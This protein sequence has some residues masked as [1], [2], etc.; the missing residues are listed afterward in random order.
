MKVSTKMNYINIIV[1]YGNYLKGNKASHV[2]VNDDVERSETSKS[3]I[4]RKL[5]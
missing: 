5:D 3:N 4:L 2:Q 1:D